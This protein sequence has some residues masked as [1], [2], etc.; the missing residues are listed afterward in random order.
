MRLRGKLPI[1]SRRDLYNL[2]STLASIIYHGLKAFK[3]DLEREIAEDGVYG[4]PQWVFNELGIDSKHQIPSKEDDEKALQYW[5]DTLELMIYGF[6]EK[7]EP[8]MDN[9]NF[10]LEFKT[11]EKTKYGTAVEIVCDNEVEYERYRKDVEV[12]EKKAQEG[13]ELFGKH[14]TSLWT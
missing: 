10:N 1:F 6:D 4:T 12:Y 8:N 3:E 13:R 14:F 11:G 9:Y 5:L 2:D 7:A